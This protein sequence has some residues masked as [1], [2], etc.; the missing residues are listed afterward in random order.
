MDAL[1]IT[2][3]IREPQLAYLGALCAVFGSVIGNAIL[4]GIARKGGET[5]LAKHISKG[6]G[7]RLHAWFQRYGLVTVF[8]PAVS[9][10]P[11]P[12]KVPVFCS[13]A[14]GVR[15]GAFLATVA[16]ARAIRY[17]TLA[18]LGRRFGAS[19]LF[20]LKQHSVGAAVI[21]LVLAV[22]VF[23]VLRMSQQRPARTRG[24]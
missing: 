17:F 19:T 15:L 5:F 24:I 8:I 18:Y 2:V 11:M 21:T 7:K 23:F 13:G 9:F 22:A 20:W 12:V 1:T 14:L 16:A 10:I 3:A 6:T 4:F